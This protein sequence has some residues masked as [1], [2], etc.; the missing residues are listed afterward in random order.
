MSRS[1]NPQRPFNP[2]RRRDGR[3]VFGLIAVLIGALALLHTLHII[4]SLWYTMHFGW[5]IVLIV[6]G[7]F[8]GVKNNFR[9]NAW[10]I[11]ILIGAAHLI[12][13]FTIG[14]VSSARLVWPALLILAG[15]AMIFRSKNCKQ[16]DKKRLEMV[17]NGESTLHIDVTMGGRKEIVTSKEF[18]GGHVSTT[19]GGTEINLMQA[20]STVQPMVLDIRVSF[21]SV[22]LIVPSHWEV[23][24]EIN[25]SMGS[26][27]DHR[28]ARTPDISQDKRTLMLRGSCS[29]GSI[30][31][32]SY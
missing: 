20:D 25:P 30:E 15:L 7:I 28:L 8:L 31:I 19:F 26:V 16:W 2:Q 13:A 32:K 17:T 9:R 3:I 14:D 27:E 18:R 5:P 12:P 21:G 24:N 1:H 29:F 6:I 11:L 10:W 23:I 4:P 22:E